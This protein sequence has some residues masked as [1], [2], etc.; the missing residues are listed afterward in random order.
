MMV[1]REKEGNIRKERSNGK[2]QH[3]LKTQVETRVLI[4]KKWMLEYFLDA[5]THARIHFEQ[6]NH[7]RQS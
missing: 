4:S 6:T 2:Q 7:Q 1:Y 3:Q 5:Q